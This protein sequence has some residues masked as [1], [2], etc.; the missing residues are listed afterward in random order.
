MEPERWHRVEEL[1]H[2]ALKVPASERAALLKH[3]C[4]GDDK[5]REEVESLLSCE[6]SAVE[7][8][9]S[10]A[11]DVAARLMVQGNTCEK[12]LDAVAIPTNASRNQ[13]QAHG[14]TPG[15]I[16][17]DRYRVVSLMGHGGMGEVYGADD[18]QLGQR[19]A[20]KFLPTDRGMSSTWRNQFF[21]EVR[22]ARQVSHPNVCRVYD[23]G[24]SEGK[25]F[26]SMEFVDGE[27]LA[28]L[29]RRIGRLPD[30][31]AIEIAQQLCF[32]LA[33]AHRS[34]VL[35]RDLKPSN[36]MIDGKGH[37]RITD[38][39]LA[40][41]ASDA[42]HQSSL[43]GTP[44]YLAPELLSGS[45]P[46]VQS[47]LY[48]AGLVLYELFT[49]KRAFESSSLDELY[50]K[51]RETDP[52][53]PSNVVRNFD[54]AVERAILPCLHRDPSRRPRSALSVAAALS[55]RDPLSVALAAGETPSPEMVA[56]AGPEG[57][58][59]PAVAWTCLAVAV[60]LI[61]GTSMLLA[62]HTTDWGL[63]Y[64]EKAPEVLADRAQVLAEKLGYAAAVDRVFWV[65]SE[66]NYLDYV[67]H[68]A[69]R[70]DWRRSVAG[71]AWPSPVAFWYRQSPEWMTPGMGE[72]NT[73]SG[74]P[75]VTQWDPP[76]ETSG[77]VTVKLDMQGKLLFFRAVPPQID[78]GGERLEPDWDMLFAEAGL[79]K[80]H[81]APA[82]PKWVP[83]ET[84]DSRMDWEGEATERPDLR[85]HVSA[86][87]YRGVPVYFQ[88]IAPWDKPW[89]NSAANQQSISA[90]IS[91]AVW[92]F[93][94]VGYLVIGGFFA[95]RNIRR[96]RGD[97]KG[98]LLLAAFTS[99]LLVVGFLLTY[100]Y[101]PRPEYIV[102]QFII[103]GIPL[104]AGMLAW[105]GYMAVE[106]YA[107]RRWPKLLVSWQRILSGRIRD[108]L[109]GR[110]LLW[111]ILAGALAATFV[112]GMIARMSEA[113]SVDPSFGQGLR[114]SIGSSVSRLAQACLDGLVC[115]AILSIMTGILRKRWLGLVATGL[116]LLAIYR[117]TGGLDLVVGL[118]GLLM[119][120]AVL[121]R[122]GLVAAG[123]FLVV[124]QT[125]YSSPP[126]DM[127]QWY[128]GRA[129]FALLVPMALLL[130]GFYVSVGGQ[131]IFGNLL[132]EE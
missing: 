16:V 31:K 120:M 44:G 99:L 1:Y 77:L 113:T 98:A 118:V 33:A 130:I 17:A 32:G 47:D 57:S 123:G 90:K 30:D 55:G 71:R 95:R 74:P 127:T 69:S 64:M 100:H 15:T 126:L 67:V 24:E 53:P 96:G 56:V 23:I 132:K 28:S 48:S 10:P 40:M 3:E 129:A 92:A 70:V 8:M 13:S 101:V 27:D 63:A 108:P 83:P 125:I 21:A 49:G 54:P 103:F 35:H 81:F 20:L 112:A 14:F 5:L 42:S 37:V 43:A 80:T 22:L 61:L 121:A 102:L 111:G 66:Q 131:P 36:V 6:N 91:T 106:P 29:L 45:A 115:V 34:G 58:L 119:F 38:F 60:T 82:N 25:L 116:V 41:V 12:T 107:R 68:N 19:V 39:G 75:T 85:V 122:V 4:Q 11:F 76:Y 110:D 72:R 109:V 46:S 104:F 78:S 79:D 9:E 93:V 2:A 73:I 88:V 50:R 97:S 128:G 18:L 117:A 7:F 124:S 84:F 87:A 94:L 26:L 51:Q 105:I 52:I 86:A 114:P 89:R 65:D 62:P 59:R